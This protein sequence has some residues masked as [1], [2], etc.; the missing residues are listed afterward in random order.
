MTSRSPSS[1]DLVRWRPGMARPARPQPGFE[2][3]VGTGRNL[4]LPRPSA[5]PGA[6]NSAPRCS[7]PPSQRAAGLCRDADLP[8]ATPSTCRSAT[9]CSTPWS[10]RCR[11]APFP[12]RPRRSANESRPSPRSQLVLDHIGST[13]PPIYAAMALE[14]SPI[15]TDG[16]HFT[17][18]QLPLVQAGRTQIVKAERLK[19]GPSGAS[20]PS[21]PREV[22]AT[23]LDAGISSPGSPDRWSRHDPDG[24]IFQ[25]A[26]GGILQDSGY[27]E[28]WDQPRQTAL[29][30]AQ[31][32]VTAR[33]PPQRPAARRRLLVAELRCARDRGRPP[34]R[35]RRR[36][37]TRD[38]RP[39]HRRPGCC[40]Q[41]AHHRRPRHPRRRGQT[42]VTKDDDDTE[43]AS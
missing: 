6:R 4:P 19:A 20:T 5:P 12:A 21:S 39:L 14:R 22:S 33:P 43:Q 23:R 30:S 31:Y 3:A 24:R 42:R 29:T 27:N 34:R 8:K 32:R 36:G 13:W 1:R 2:V 17:R 25:T 37:P 10:A 40:R 35:A 18:R 26:R 41:P 28:V 11:C 9:R 16:E 7:V 38:L 15:R